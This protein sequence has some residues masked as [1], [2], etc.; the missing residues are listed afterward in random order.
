MLEAIVI[1][2]ELAKS[3]AKPE[4]V[5]NPG[6]DPKDDF[7]EW[8]EKETDGVIGSN[9]PVVAESGLS[10]T[11]YVGTGALLAVER[12]DLSGVVYGWQLEAQRGL[13]QLHGVELRQAL[14]QDGL[15]AGEGSERSPGA[16][17]P[18]L[19]AWLQERSSGVVGGE[20]VSQQAGLGMA[21]ASARAAA[22]TA[23]SDAL[24]QASHGM[25][26]ASLTWPERYL[27]RLP[28][29]DGSGVTLWLRDYRLDPSQMGATVD[30]L[31]EQHM[32]SQPVTR[33]VVN[34]TEVWRLSSYQPTEET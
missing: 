18:A 11:E 8:V 25:L 13:S 10:G 24:E 27:R 7:S 3:H 19:H 4:P 2:G 23:G 1:K 29:M 6:S 30:A 21:Q 14:S 9:E 26:A 28:N 15:R 17:A 33:I 16:A 32:N 22:M 12:L 31:I 20:S 5:R 34:G